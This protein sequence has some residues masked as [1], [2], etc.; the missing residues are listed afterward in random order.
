MFAKL[1]NTKQ[2]FHVYSD[3]V[4]SMGTHHLYLIKEKK[5]KQKTDP[6]KLSNL[7]RDK[8]LGCQGWP[9]TRAHQRAEMME[10]SWA[11]G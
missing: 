2:T 8:M 5:Q 10:W 3:E 1:Q 9:D 4:G 11:L 6:E 7:P